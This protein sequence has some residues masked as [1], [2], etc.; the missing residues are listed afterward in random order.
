VK[1][2]DRVISRRTE[3]GVPT[4]VHYPLPLHRQ[5]LYRS[6][7][8]PLRM[9]GELRA[10]ESA[11]SGVMSLPIYAAIDED[12]QDYIVDSLFSSLSPD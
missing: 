2:R 11:S 1:H 3:L 8:L 12:L 9:S 6:G 5:P 10:S 4:A 7:A